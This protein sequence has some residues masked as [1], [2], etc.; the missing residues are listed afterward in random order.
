MLCLLIMINFTLVD[1]TTTRIGHGWVHNIVTRIYKECVI[2]VL[3]HKSVETEWNSQVNY[4]LV[5]LFKNEFKMKKKYEFIDK[6]SLK[7]V[8]VGDTGVGKSSL[9]SRLSSRPFHIEY[10]P[11]VFDNFAG[12]ILF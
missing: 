1:T 5:I 8:I 3:F 2:S 6:Q 11:T 9:A 7:L 4:I 10:K 12:K